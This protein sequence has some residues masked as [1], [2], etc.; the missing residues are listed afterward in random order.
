MR[1]GN[2]NNKTIDSSN[3]IQSIENLIK[4]KNTKNLVLNINTRNL[5]NFKNF[6]KKKII[7]KSE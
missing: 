6:A 1:N 7:K 4:Y 3:I 5:S 2:K